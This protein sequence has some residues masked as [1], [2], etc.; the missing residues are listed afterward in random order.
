MKNNNIL[1]LV[2]VGFI[3]LFF[4]IL[5]FLLYIVISYNLSDTSSNISVTT[6]NNEFKETVEDVV[7]EYDCKFYKVD[8]NKIY[9]RFSKNLFDDN[10]KSNE[11]YFKSI[12]NDLSRFYEKSDFYLID[13]NKE[14]EIFAKYDT[15][16]EK[17]V[18]VIN[19]IEDY[20]NNVDGNDYVEINNIKLPKESDTI[21]SVNSLL[22]NLKDSGMKFSSIEE[23]L[24]EGTH[25]DNGYISYLNNTVKLRIVGNK[26]V[27]NI[28][29]SRKYDEKIFNNVDNDA[30][31]E[32][33]YMENPNNCYGGIEEGYLGYRTNQLYYYIYDDEISV[34]GYSYTKNVKFEELLE[35]YL[36]NKNFERFIILLTGQMPT[37]DYCEYD[38]ENK[39]ANIML[40]SYGIEIDIKD[41]DPKGIILYNN[42]CFT[43]DSKKLV[44]NGLITFKNDENSI[45]KMEIE[46]RKK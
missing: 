26:V 33:F 12:V 31:L 17:H 41:N 10:G 9:V 34:Y 6:A 38:V 25:L 20:Y 4:A 32:E 18:I 30:S 46:R 19:S 43:D 39:T 37:Y 42:Y 35:K 36:D 27:R 44:K 15:T 2:I 16:N 24:G 14:L 22:T 1:R 3:L 8:N 29:F 23:E 5:C 45:E 11:N 40:S 28:V 13:N 7:I 21:K